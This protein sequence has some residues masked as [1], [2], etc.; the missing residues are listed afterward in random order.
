MQSEPVGINVPPR[1]PKVVVRRRICLVNVDLRLPQEGICR[2]V[3]KKWL[4]EANNESE[5]GVIYGQ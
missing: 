1:Y 5:N 4:Y 3:I 2:G